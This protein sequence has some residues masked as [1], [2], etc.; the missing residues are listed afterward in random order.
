MTRFR[1]RVKNKLGYIR[2]P[3]TTSSIL[4]IYNFCYALQDELLPSQQMTMQSL[5]LKAC[6]S[7]NN[8]KSFSLMAF[9]QYAQ[10]EI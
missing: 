1:V 10:E 9:P 6:F 5:Y 3:S 4:Y 2:T 7:E 8:I